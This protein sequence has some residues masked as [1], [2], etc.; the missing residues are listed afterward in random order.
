MVGFELTLNDGTCSS[1]YLYNNE[2]E[3]YPLPKVS[4]AFPNPAY[5]DVCEG[6]DWMGNLEGASGLAY[7]GPTTGE[8]YNVSIDAVGP[9]A[10]EVPW[11]EID[12]TVDNTT[13]VTLTLN[14]EADYGVAVC[15]T[16]WDLTLDVFD[17]PEVNLDN[18]NLPESICVG[19]TV[20]VSSSFVPG[21]G[22]GS[23]QQ[24]DYTWTNADDPGVFDIQL[25]Q[26]GSIATIGVADVQTFP[27][28]ATF[29]S[30]S[31]TPKDA[32]PK[33][34]SPSPSLN[35]RVWRTDFGH[36]SCGVLRN[37]V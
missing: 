6:A 8:V 20:N 9:I 21:S 11:S 24:M 10:W 14:A 36:A 35:P 5:N 19:S 22:N 27:T 29:S 1:S 2:L 17:A 31:P 25:V 37:I 15:Q 7:T 4:L 23:G 16:T 28:K 33:K 13:P 26:N 3:L 12:L 18:T 32:R 30:T 34:R